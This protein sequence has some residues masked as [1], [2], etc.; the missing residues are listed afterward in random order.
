ML[1]PLLLREARVCKGPHALQWLV[2]HSTC[3]HSYRA[4][5][6]HG[7]GKHHVIMAESYYEETTESGCDTCHKGDH[8]TGPSAA[9]PTKGTKAPMGT[10]APTIMPVWA[11]TAA[12]VTTTEEPTTAAPTPGVACAQ[13]SHDADRLRPRQCTGSFS[14]R[15]SCYQLA[16]VSTAAQPLQ[17][18][19]QLTCQLA[20]LSAGPPQSGSAPG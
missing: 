17:P 14:S 5:C 13:C 3:S 20:Q 19:C 11:T 1:S 16:V 2:L 7:C 15:L 9:P 6:R 4:P 10:P 18:C 12:P 8:P